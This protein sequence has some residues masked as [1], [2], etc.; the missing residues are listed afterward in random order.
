[1][2]EPLFTFTD[3]VARVCPALEGID[4]WKAVRH[5][6]N[7]PEVPD[8][9]ELFHLDREALEFYQ[10]EQSKGV[11]GACDGVFSFLGLP[12]RRALFVGGYQVRGSRTA[13]MP[14]PSTVPGALRGMYEAR[15]RDEPDVVRYYYDLVRDPR[16]AALEMRVVVD[17]GLGA[18]SWHQWAL[19]KPVVELRDPNSLGPCP[20]YREINLTLA[21]LAFL[22]RHEEANP[23]WRDKLSAVGGIYLLTDRAHGRLYVG[24]AGGEAGFWG[25]WKEYAEQRTG[26][27]VIDPAFDAGELHPES[28][29]LSI[30]D[31]VPKSASA[32]VVLDRLEVRWKERLC[33]RTT[34]YNRN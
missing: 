9:V 25:R 10:A 18:L 24:Q 30:L 16:F 21:K 8:L 6:D 4:K 1:M 20:D 14:D 31:I 27:V 7:R 33:T 3:L 28:T 19:D 32:K 29:T 15:R 12:G 13:T 26:N 34:G 2:P 22:I 23:S 17:W 11:F 5:L